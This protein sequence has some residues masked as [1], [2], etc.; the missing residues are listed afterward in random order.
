MFG[1]TQLV[2]SSAIE[3]IAQIALAAITSPDGE[4]RHQL[5][6][7]EEADQRGIDD[8]EDADLAQEAFR[9]IEQGREQASGCDQQHGHR[10]GDDGVALDG[11]A[12]EEGR[13]DHGRLLVVG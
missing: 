11:A 10:A 3:S 8:E 12:E 2:N 13:V 7:S 9:Q 4:L 5:A 1:C 6:R